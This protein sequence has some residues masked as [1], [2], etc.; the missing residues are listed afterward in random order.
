[1]TNMASSMESSINKGCD[2]IF[3]FNC[4]TCQENENDRN[5][6]AKFYCEE[7][8]K[9]FCGKCVEL[10]NSLFKKHAL[11]G[12]ENISQWPETDVVE[13]QQCK[14][15]R[16]EKLTIFCEDHSQVICHVCHFHNHQ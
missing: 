11:L 15:H 14:E 7:C 4:F 5:T 8:S 3:D 1:M 10:H 12:K 16:K 9:F 6:E 2:F 13:L